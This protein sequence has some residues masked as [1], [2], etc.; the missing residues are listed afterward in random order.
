MAQEYIHPAEL[1]QA[2]HAV[3]NEPPPSMMQA[4]M[5]LP[6]QS[7]EQSSAD[8]GRTSNVPRA[9]P[10]TKNAEETSGGQISEMER[11]PTVVDDSRQT[12]GGYPQEQLFGGGGLSPA[13]A[14]SS[15][16]KHS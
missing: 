16:V 2:D 13:R 10:R 3:L 6:L 4:E 7:Q 8:Q 11:M 1:Q 12:P 14:G 5:E 15:Q 9:E